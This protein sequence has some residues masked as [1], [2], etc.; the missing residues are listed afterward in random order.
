M[1]FDYDRTACYRWRAGGVV[2]TALALSTCLLLTIYVA[3]QQ[4]RFDGK[5]LW[6]HVEVLP[7]DH[8]EGRGTGTPG[9]DRAQPYV[10]D[11]LSTGEHREARN[12]RL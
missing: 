8:M 4:R 12:G 10:V 7:A 1:Y 11:H 9:L 5:S 6:G 2:K 3:A